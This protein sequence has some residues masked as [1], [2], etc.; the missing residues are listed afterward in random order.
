M[1]QNLEIRK[2]EEHKI[3]VTFSDG[4]QFCMDSDGDLNLESAGSNIKFSCIHGYELEFKVSKRE[5]L[6]V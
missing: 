1:N 4:C 6:P 2:V 3:A 5:G